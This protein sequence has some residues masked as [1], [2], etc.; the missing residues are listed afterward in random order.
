MKVI[1]RKDIKDKSMNQIQL[2]NKART[3]IE[4]HALSVWLEH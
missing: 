4:L 3:L 1:A 2:F